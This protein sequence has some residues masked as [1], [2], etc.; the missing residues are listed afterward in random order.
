MFVGDAHHNIV[1]PGNATGGT[2]QQCSTV[3]SPTIK[4]DGCDGTAMRRDVG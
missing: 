4:C 3:W 1:M 2:A